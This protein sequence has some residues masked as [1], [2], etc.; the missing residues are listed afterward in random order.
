MQLLFSEQQYINK[1]SKIR[2]TAIFYFDNCISALPFKKCFYS[3]ITIAKFYFV[4]YNQSHYFK[5]I[6]L[7]SIRI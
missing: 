5:V 7:S 3:S 6:E 2:F 1:N 4:I